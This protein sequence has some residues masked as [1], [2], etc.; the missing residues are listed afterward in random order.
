M[1][2]DFFEHT[3]NKVYQNCRAV[4]F[5]FISPLPTT[6]SYIKFGG[7]EMSYNWKG[8]TR[9]VKEVVG[10]TEI[11]TKTV[12]FNYKYALQLMNVETGEEYDFPHFVRTMAHEIAH[13]LL[14]DY[15]PKYLNIDDPHNLW[16]KLLTGQLELYLWT[17]PEILELT[18]LQNKTIQ[19][20]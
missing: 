12:H 1:L 5:F 6:S 19:L 9:P 4:V 17:L 8:R 18:N 13:C 3:I 14:L 20:I 7:W 16:H 11:I 2:Q 15:D 10:N